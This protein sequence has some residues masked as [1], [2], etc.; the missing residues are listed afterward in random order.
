[1]DGRHGWVFLLWDGVLG[2]STYATDDIPVTADT[3]EIG[4]IKKCWLLTSNTKKFLKHGF[5]WRVSLTARSL[6]FVWLWPEPKGRKLFTATTSGCSANSRRC[7]FS[8]SWHTRLHIAYNFN[9]TNHK[10][11]LVSLVFLDVCVW[12]I[13]IAY[14]FNWRMTL[15]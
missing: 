8:G 10:L 9:T 6:C 5:H 14:C 15:F 1:M 7:R 13:A 2:H 3:G 4:S 12:C 11:P